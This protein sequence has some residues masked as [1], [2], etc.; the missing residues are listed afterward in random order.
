MGRT[1]ASN[2]L[3]HPAR[4][5]LHDA[6]QY[7]GVVLSE[8]QEQ[9]HHP[10]HRCC[11][12]GSLRGWLDETGPEPAWPGLL[13]ARLGGREPGSLVGL[14]HTQVVGN[15]LDESGVGR[16]VARVGGRLSSTWPPP[17]K[18]QVELARTADRPLPLRGRAPAQIG[19]SPGSL[20]PPSS[21]AVPCQATGHR[22][23]RPFGWRGPPPLCRVG[24]TIAAA[25]ATRM[26]N[27][28]Y[29][30]DAAPDTLPDLALAHHADLTQG[31]LKSAHTWW[32]S[33]WRDRELLSGWWPLRG[34]QKGGAPSPG[35]SGD[36]VGA[37]RAR[38]VGKRSPE[39][40]RR[41]G[42]PITP[43]PPGR[44]RRAGDARTRTG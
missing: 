10:E 39:R 38:R 40:P 44:P 26:I 25:T 22:G 27:A 28:P 11:F 31:A 24:M 33:P 14:Q 21:P 18:D 7:P 30:E 13:L 29:P 36:L 23:L 17:T 20:S 2:H 35:R 37:W 12:G 43:S 8:H 16:R 6:D 4:F 1:V 34:Q 9:E 3:D 5:L 15:V 42:P 19:W 32:S 41:T